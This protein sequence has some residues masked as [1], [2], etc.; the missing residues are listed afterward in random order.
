MTREDKKKEIA[1]LTS[2]LDS[3]DAVYVTDSSELT[4]EEVSQLRRKCHKEGVKMRVTKN[5]LAIKA[6]EA[7]EKDFSELYDTLKG[8]TS[9]MFAERANTPA[10]VIKDFRKKFDKPI[11]KGAYID[12]EVY[13]GDDQVTPLS[14]LKS[15]EELIGEVIGLL[16]SP[17]KNVVSAL[18]SGQNNITGVLKTLSERAE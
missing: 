5:T 6:M 1:F 12:S 18:Q 4:V 17:I 9:L 10:K 15:K 8:S 11:L 16:Q 2:Q 3:Y 13:I 14:E 7:H